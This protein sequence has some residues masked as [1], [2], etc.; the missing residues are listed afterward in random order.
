MQRIPYPD[1]S[2]LPGIMRKKL[3]NLQWVASNQVPINIV[4]TAVTGI[5]RD[6]DALGHLPGRLEE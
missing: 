3:V 2:M 4:L 6:L 5:E 1:V